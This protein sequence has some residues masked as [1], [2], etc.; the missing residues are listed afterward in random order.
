MKRYIALLLVL[1]SFMGWGCGTNTKETSADNRIPIAASFYPMAEF[2]RAVGGERV[3]V[4]TMIPDGVEPHDWEPSPRVLTKL[5]KQR[6]LIYN[7]KVEPWAPQALK[8][9]EERP[10]RGV[11]TGQNLYLCQGKEDPHVWIS[12][13]KAKLQVQA[14]TEALCE[15][16]PA[17]RTV[18]QQNSKAY[19][20]E[21][22]A[23]DRKLKQVVENS[24]RKCFVT[25]HA[26]FSHLAADYG[27]E[28]IALKGLSPEAEPTPEALTRAA[29]LIR[30]KQMKYI[31]FETLTSPKITQVLAKE[32]GA[33]TLV[34]DPIEGLDEE[35]QR[36][37]LTYIKLMQ[38]NIEALEKALKE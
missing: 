1:L 10:L 23:L 35:G 29:K 32:T 3:K 24:D 17:G 18:Y 13:Q 7:G 30:E 15:L 33:G 4:W 19:L 16:D 25:A 37:S 6:L 11:E 26:A 22:E 31:F 12:P 38:E 36:N 8:A 2:T 34:L 14:I 20:Q 9:L 21:L 28:Q 27:L 5:G